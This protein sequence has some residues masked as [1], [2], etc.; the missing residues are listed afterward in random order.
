MHSVSKH[1]SFGAH[2]K[3][4]NEDR[5]ILPAAMIQPMT[6]VS[7][8]HHIHCTVSSVCF[9]NWRNSWNGRNLLMMRML[10]TLQVASWQTKIRNSS[11]M[12]SG[13]WS[14]FGKMLGQV[15]FSWCRQSWQTVV[16][17]V[18]LPNFLNTPC[19]S[20]D[21]DPN[22]I[23]LSGLVDITPSLVALTYVK[24]LG[25]IVD[26]DLTFEKNVSHLSQTC[27][28]HLS[29]LLTAAS[30]SSVNAFSSLTNLTSEIFLR[31]QVVH[32]RWHRFFRL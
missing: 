27:F 32:F 17:C 10:S 19:T 22:R 8:N 16:N 1:V 12:E 5:S 29:T 31:M 14:K 24:D 30:S 2:H 6:L 23:L 7:G 25:V 15:H 11:T 9:P 26:S 18:K 20:F 21:V 4:L 3:N 28:F 13:L